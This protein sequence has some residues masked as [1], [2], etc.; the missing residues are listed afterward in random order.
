MSIY[1]LTEYSDIYSKTLGSLWQYYRYKLA[2]DNYNDIIVFLADICGSTLFNFKLKI[3]GKTGNDFTKHVEIMVP[4]KY[5]SNFRRN[6]EI[7]LINCEINFQLKSPASSFLVAGTEANQVSALIMT[8]T[9]LY[10]PGLWY[11][12]A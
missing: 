9:K 1:N 3:T 4:L 8:D 12:P 5:L 10:V 6:L 7:P 2:F 11:K